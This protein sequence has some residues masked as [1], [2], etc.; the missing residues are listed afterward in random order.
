M[1]NAVLLTALF[2][3]EYVFLNW[4]FKIL[5]FTLEFNADIVIAAITPIITRVMRTSA[6][7]KPILGFSFSWG[8]V[9]AFS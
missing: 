4:L 1:S 2:R 5:R 8:G 3:V 7:V 6:N 9:S